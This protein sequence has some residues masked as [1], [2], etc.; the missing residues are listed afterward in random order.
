MLK[1]IVVLFVTVTVGLFALSIM[2]SNH[3]VGAP[4]SNQAVEQ[5]ISESEDFVQYRAMFIASTKK[6]VDEGHCS[7]EAL[8][9]LGGWDKSKNFESESIYFVYCGGLRT[10][11][12]YLNT[13]TGEAY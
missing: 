6:L 7:L 2:D 9:E 8:K 11:K 1:N 13:A 5:A 3:K 4:V 10:S 12:Y